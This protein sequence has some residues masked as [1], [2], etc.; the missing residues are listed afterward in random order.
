MSLIANKVKY[1]GNKIYISGTPIGGL[2]GAFTLYT[3]TI[4]NQTVT[5]YF[6]SRDFR[7]SCAGR[8]L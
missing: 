4:T 3:E 1:E 5:D 8:F 2:I 6:V 7:Y